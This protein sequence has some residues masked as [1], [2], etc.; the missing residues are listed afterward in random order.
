MMIFKAFFKPNQQGKLLPES[1]SL[2]A[3]QHQPVVPDWLGLPMPEALQA[4]S[5]ARQ[6][7][8]EQKNPSL[9]L[10][11]LPVNPLYYEG[12]LPTHWVMDLWVDLAGEAYLA[13][14][15]YERAA[16]VFER[17]G[18]PE[19]A[20]WAWLLAGNCQKTFEL[21]QPF[22]EESI[23]NQ[24]VQQSSS[25]ASGYQL[26]AL[27]PALGN[28]SQWLVTQWGLVTNQFQQWPTMLQLRN[29]IENDITQLVNANQL[30]IL[31]AYLAKMDW[32]GQ[33]NFE[34][35]KLAGRSFFYLGMFTLAYQLLLQA[36]TILV[37]DAEVYY[38]LGQ[39]YVACQQMK[40]ATLMLRQCLWINPHYQ[41]AEALLASL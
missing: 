20:G 27:K 30:A 33:V 18:L 41:P 29:A 26:S 7:L 13:S 23:A 25:S 11:L 8:W 24:S 39:Y 2:V 35:Y 4:L 32:L 34:V 15:Q 1:L 36:Q 38:H 21:W 9:C 10:L 5:P 19:R 12:T 3:G 6:A 37:T 31:D 22:L 14:K 17:Y 40:Q 28:Q 16:Q